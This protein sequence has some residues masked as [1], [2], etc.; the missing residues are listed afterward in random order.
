MLCDA[1]H[2]QRR[3]CPFVGLL[4]MCGGSGHVPE[5]E[6]DLLEKNLGTFPHLAYPRGVTD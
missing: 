1:V 5:G 6:D 2:I 4:C 3:L